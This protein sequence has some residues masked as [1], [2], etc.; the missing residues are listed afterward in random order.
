MNNGHGRARGKESQIGGSWWAPTY[1]RLAI[2]RDEMDLDL[3]LCYTVRGIPKFRQKVW[4]ETP[5]SIGR[6]SSS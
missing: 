4:Y 5:S 6:Y 2:F 1:S 3:R